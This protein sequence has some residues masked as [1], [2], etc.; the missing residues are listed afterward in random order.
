MQITYRYRVRD[1]HATRLN[2]QAAAANFVWNYCNEMQSKAAK[3]GRKWLTY[4]DLH[5]LTAGSTKEG[6]DLHSQTVQQICQQ[7]EISRRQQRKALV[8]LAQN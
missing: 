2:A 8:V 5:R 3:A 6:L 4:C 1:K 7:Y